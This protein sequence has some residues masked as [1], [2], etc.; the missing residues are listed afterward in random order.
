[1]WELGMGRGVLL[2]ATILVII[3]GVGVGEDYIDPAKIGDHFDEL[4]GLARVENGLGRDEV[5]IKWLARAII[6][7]PNV[8][9]AW[10]VPPHMGVTSHRIPASCEPSSCNVDLCLSPTSSRGSVH[11]S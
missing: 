5:A 6:V 7:M 2:I 9:V 4:C 3:L 11:P 10:C 1:M 8:T